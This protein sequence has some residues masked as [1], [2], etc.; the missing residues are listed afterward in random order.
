MEAS[1][2][3]LPDSPLVTPERVRLNEAFLVAGRDLRLPA[4]QVRL[5]AQAAMEQEMSLHSV[6]RA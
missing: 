4:N 6:D 3:N 2:V 1:Y 5:P